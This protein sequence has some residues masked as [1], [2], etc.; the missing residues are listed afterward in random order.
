LENINRERALGAL[1]RKHD[2]LAS[3][4]TVDLEFAR[5]GDGGKPTVTA[6][7]SDASGKPLEDAQHQLLP[8]PMIAVDAADL[9]Q[10]VD[11]LAK[12]ISDALAVSPGQ[13]KLDSSKE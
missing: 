3:V 4:V 1:D 11:A 7:L 9:T 6:L 10:T 13:A 5:S 2:I 8:K 12:K